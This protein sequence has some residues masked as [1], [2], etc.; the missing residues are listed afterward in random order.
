MFKNT[1]AKVSQC[2]KYTVDSCD[3]YYSEVYSL[4]YTRVYFK[5]TKS[6]MPKM[7]VMLQIID[8]CFIVEMNDT[9]TIDSF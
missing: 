5:N 9:A 8:V 1:I 6:A 3:K 7:R 4:E 2:R